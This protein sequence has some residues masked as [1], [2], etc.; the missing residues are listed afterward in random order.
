MAAF[1]LRFSPRPNRA[2]EIHWFSW[3][4]QAFAKAQEE[5]KLI[6]LAISGV[7]CHWCHVMDETTYSDPQIIKFIN[8]NLV[9]IRVDTDQRPDINERYNLDGWPTTAI[10]SPQGELLTG[11][12][13]I[14]P[15]E[16][17]TFLHR[18][19]KSYRE[20]RELFLRP[21]GEY[22]PQ[23][24]EGRVAAGDITEEIINQV[25]QEVVK[26]YDE[27][28]GG[29]GV[30]PKFPMSE[31][32]EL[33]M[34]SYVETGEEQW[35]TIFSHTL[36]QMSGS[37]MYDPVEGGFFRYSTTRDWSIPHFEKM[38][39]DNALL[40]GNLLMAYQITGEA[41]FAEVARDVLRYLE[42]NLYSPDTGAWAG[43]Q[44]ADEEYY[45][46]PMTA[47]RRHPAPFID[48]IIY[49]NWNGLLV[50]SLL[51]A[52]VIFRNDHWKVRAL[53]TIDFLLRRCYQAEKGMAHYYD[54]QPHVW[55]LL[56]DEIAVGFA[57]NMAYQVTGEEKF[58]R[59]SE[60]LA[61]YCLTRLQSPAGGFYDSLPDPNALGALK[62]P[63]VDFRHNAEAARWL[64]EL[65]ALTH[66]KRYLTAARRAL[67]A[68]KKLYRRYDVMAAG[69]ALAVSEVLKPWTVVTVVGEHEQT[70][71]RELLRTALIN[72]T[73]RRVAYLLD[74]RTQ[75][76]LVAANGYDPG[77]P[78]KAYVCIGERCFQPLSGTSELARLLRNLGRC[79]ETEKWGD[80]QCEAAI[81]QVNPKRPEVK[82]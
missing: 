49:V 67:A 12:T 50:R 6:L 5:D 34:V 36:T 74:P 65:A 45:A 48:R 72:F 11:G 25:R 77:P 37:R 16:M 41:R 18:V 27:R 24:R 22:A 20:N 59:W 79:N 75:A 23:Q 52:A 43:T 69:Y 71:P 63:L 54:G 42:S 17:K 28:Y 14:P 44:D 9:A 78:A 31:A 82:L 47:R 19:V 8:D 13:Y 64:A 15:A 29:F 60:K 62:K 56:I 73:P 26:N 21:A 33:A 2:R 81:N 70:A 61:E 7:W 1:H 76:E 38:L 53:S 55:G 30:A 66:Q 35:R 58:I 80:I 10:L 51:Q 32:L 40:L 57:L 3:E 46:L 4:E 68:G 39:E